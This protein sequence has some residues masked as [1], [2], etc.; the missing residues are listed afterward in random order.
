MT[1]WAYKVLKTQQ[2]S[3]GEW[4]RYPAAFTTADQ[5]E[6]VAYAERFAAE[7]TAAGVARTRILVLARKGDRVVR[8]F[9]VG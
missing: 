3:Q 6:A 8:E 1:A 2:G 7:Q 5:A 9:R 4:F